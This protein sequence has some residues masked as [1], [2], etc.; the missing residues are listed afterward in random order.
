MQ[1]NQ[2]TVIPHIRIYQITHAETHEVPF[3]PIIRS[4]PYDGTPSRPG[5]HSPQ[6]Q[7]RVGGSFIIGGGLTNRI[8]G[9]YG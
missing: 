4:R 3:S 8:R 9:K 6:E 2:S 5:L 1:T 7:N